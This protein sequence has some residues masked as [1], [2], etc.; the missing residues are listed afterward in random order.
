VTT[1][2]E[3]LIDAS[4][5]LPARLREA[6]ALSRLCEQLV[7]LLGL[8]VVAPPQW[9][10]FPGEGGVTGL[11][12]LSESHLAVHTFPEHG[13]LALNLY[14]CRER[15]AP[16][17]GALCREHVGATAVQLRELKRGPA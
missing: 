17:F 15:P 11:L 16:D 2:Q 4:G 6:A 7:G 3:W 5:C 12:L 1:G 8:Q 10:T 9:H 13:F 14:S